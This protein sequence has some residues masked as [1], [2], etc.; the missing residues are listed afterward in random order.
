MKFEAPKGQRIK[1]YG[2]GVTIMTG[3]WAWLYDEKRW[4]DWVKEDCCGK[5]RSSHAPCRT[6][7]AFRRMLKKNPQ[8]PRGS[9]VWVNRY[10]GHNAIA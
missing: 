6:I 7:R 4:A 9:I 2:M 3:H 10:I 8:L 1:R 5:S